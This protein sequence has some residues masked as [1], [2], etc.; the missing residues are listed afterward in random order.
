MNTIILQCNER[1]EPDVREWIKEV[2]TELNEGRSL[3]YCS[4]SCGKVR[5]V[6]VGD[7]FFLQRTGNGP[8][9]YFASGYVIDALP[10]EQLKLQDSNYSKLSAAYLTAF[11]GDSFKICL[12]IDTIIDFDQPLKID[13]L[14][15]LPAFSGCEFRRYGSGTAFNPSYTEE[16][17]KE[18]D[19][20]S[21]NLAP[22]KLATRLIDS[23]CKKAATA[24]REKDFNKAQQ[25]YFEAIQVSERSLMAWRGLA[26]TARELDEC[27]IALEA[28]G[29]A[30]NLATDKH[31]LYLNRGKVFAQMH[32]LKEAEND[33]TEAVRLLPKLAIEVEK[34][35][36]S[37]KQNNPEKQHQEKNELGVN[38]PEPINNSPQKLTPNEVEAYNSLKNLPERYRK[39]ITTIRIGQESFRKNLLEFWETCAVTK[40]STHKLLIASHIKPW[41]KSNDKEKL[42]KFN[43]L[44]LVPSLDK[45]FDKGYISFDNT[46]K[47][48]IS[49]SLSDEDAQTLG[50]DKKLQLQKID[51]R[52]QDYLEYH[53]THIFKSIKKW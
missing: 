53:R 48:I 10:E 20:Y 51:V 38:P 16:L 47:I 25:L 32:R 49:P 18:W 24:R 2:Q 15:S 46:G 28:Y 9:G 11:Y 36:Q 45:A 8:R 41:S 23:L 34:L 50:I 40:C 19:S 5:K 6:Q 4:W 17:E 29:Q 26:E 35:R 31:I 13:Y 52:H 39:A 1:D 21:A 14:Q 27:D 37:F 3:Y 42:D 12:E 22:Q 44:L 33:W 30:I 7:R 43:G